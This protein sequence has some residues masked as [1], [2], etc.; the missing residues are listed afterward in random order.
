[1]L[2]NWLAARRSRAI[3]QRDVLTDQAR[4]LLEADSP[5]PS[6]LGMDPAGWPLVDLAE[7]LAFS[8]VW[9]VRGN[10]ETIV[11]LCESSLNA[12]MTDR[13]R[14]A[15]GLLRDVALKELTA[16]TRGELQAALVRLSVKYPAIDPRFGR[17]RQ[18]IRLRLSGRNL[19]FPVERSGDIADLGEI[20]EAAQS[21]A[22]R[23]LSMQPGVA[24]VCWSEK[25]WLIRSCW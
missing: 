15:I 9:K 13:L 3:Q 19:V 17:R 8:D 12:E 21:S 14:G 2:S 5:D 10:A 23:I 11:G 25:Q 22:V 24:Q 6:V 4:L 7:M 20:C 16:P 18:L 1:M